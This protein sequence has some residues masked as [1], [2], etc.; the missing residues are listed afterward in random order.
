MLF[1]NRPVKAAM[2]SVIVNG[3]V[4]LSDGKSL[5]K[6]KL[7]T[8]HFGGMSEN[9]LAIESESSHSSHNS[10]FWETVSWFRSAELISGDLAFAEAHPTHPFQQAVGWLSVQRSASLVRSDGWSDWAEF[11]RATKR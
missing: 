6:T 3:G 7:A 8:L 2:G 1:H 11:T 5:V 4:Q 10:L 9:E